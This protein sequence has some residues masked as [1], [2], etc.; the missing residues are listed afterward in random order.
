MRLLWID[1]GQTQKALS[2]RNNV[3][4]NTTTAVIVA[5]ERAGLVT[6]KRDPADRRRSIVRLT[7]KGRALR[8]KL[9]P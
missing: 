6:R 1:D 8:P 3:A 4:E 2:R 5:M 7:G 9:I